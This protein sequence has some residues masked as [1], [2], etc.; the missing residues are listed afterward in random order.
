M[1]VKQFAS[2]NNI[3][4]FCKACFQNMVAVHLILSNFRNVRV[5]ILCEIYLKIHTTKNVA[6]AKLS[7]SCLAILTGPL[8]VLEK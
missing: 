7:R 1:T 3:F 2:S 5:K 8:Q 4:L 6:A